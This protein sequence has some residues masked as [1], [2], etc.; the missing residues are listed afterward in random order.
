MPGPIDYRA[1][2]SGLL[3]DIIPTAMPYDP[4][5]QSLMPGMG[6]EGAMPY[7]GGSNLQGQANF[8]GQ[9]QKAL[10]GQSSRLPPPEAMQYVIQDAARMGVKPEYLMDHLLRTS[11]A[12]QGFRNPWR[13]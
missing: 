11:P 5:K 6:T 12:W 7:R 2:A 3:G 9:A 4:K 8:L 1:L 10:K 13:K